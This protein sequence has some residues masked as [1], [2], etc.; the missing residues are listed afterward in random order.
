MYGRIQTVTTIDAFVCSYM[1]KILA[2]SSSL[3]TLKFLVHNFFE[4]KVLLKIFDTKFPYKLSYFEPLCLLNKMAA[5]TVKRSI[6]FRKV[7]Q[8]TLAKIYNLY[9]TKL[10]IVLLLKLSKP[11]IITL[12]PILNNSYLD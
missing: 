8:S 11:K 10:I 3:V 2:R 9:L 4:T 6:K 1:P 5:K 12:I 7:A